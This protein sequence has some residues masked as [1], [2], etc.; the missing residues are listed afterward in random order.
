[1][2]L[3]IITRSLIRLDSTVRDS[4]NNDCMTNSHDERQWDDNDD[5][6]DDNIGVI[7]GYNE[8]DWE[9]D[10]VGTRDYGS[11]TESYRGYNEKL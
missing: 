9:D 6:T 1:M 11:I 8:W 2:L 4:L 5:R 7:K 3:V 10:N